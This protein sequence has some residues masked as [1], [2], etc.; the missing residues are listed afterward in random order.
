[1]PFTLTGE[2][3]IDNVDLGLW[4]LEIDSGTTKITDSNVSG[5]VT[6][7]AADLEV[8]NFRAS[9]ITVSGNASLKGSGLQCNGLTIT[10]DPALEVLLNG[11]TIPFGGL[12]VSSEVFKFFI[13]D[14]VMGSPTTNGPSSVSMISLTGLSSFYIQGTAYRSRRHGVLLSGCS[15]GE[16]DLQLLSPGN[17]TD[18]TYDGF[19]LEG[20]CANV[21]LNGSVRGAVLGVTN[22][23]RYG[24]SVGASCTNIDVDV[25]ISGTQ[26]GLIENLAAVGE[27]TARALVSAED[28][29]D[30][31]VLV[32]D[33]S[34][35]M[36]RPDDGTG[37]GGGGSGSAGTQLDMASYSG[38]LV[39][40]YSGS[41][42]FV[43]PFAATIIGVTVAVGEAPTGD[44]VIIDVHKNGTTI[45]T[46]QA[47]RPTIADG[48]NISSHEV[49]DVTSVSA[50]EYLTFDI[51]QIGSTTPGEDLTVIVEWAHA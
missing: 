23:P 29:D 17:E 37:V 38:E 35:G 51:D 25:E 36:Y 2:C 9:G 27:V 39:A 3:Y 13:Q 44:D 26:T 50:G 5:A 14:L 24:V 28:P 33:E 16:A 41:F 7:T 31:D 34:I 12:S 21:R 43:F 40:P 45:Y 47:N 4:D 19:R 18:N 46:T 22:N 30:G 49:P 6:V 10:G 48:S 32:W 20:A 1:M 8:S 11:L 42:L 15:N